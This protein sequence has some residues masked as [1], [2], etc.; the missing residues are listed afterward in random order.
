[1]PNVKNNTRKINISRMRKKI[2]RDLDSLNL[3]L[4]L[5]LFEAGENI[6]YYFGERKIK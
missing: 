4:I 6:V 5:H 3:L 2:R 1:M